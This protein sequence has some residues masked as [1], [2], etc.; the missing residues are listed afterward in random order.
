[1]EKWREGRRQHSATTFSAGA[2]VPAAACPRFTATHLV[3]PM[4]KSIRSGFP[5]PDWLLPS[6]ESIP[7]PLKSIRPP[8][9]PAQAPRTP[10]PPPLVA[11]A[12]ERSAPAVAG[13]EDTGGGGGSRDGDGGGDGEACCRSAPRR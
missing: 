9:V 1:M 7:L 5:P 8:S 12:A 6:S 2:S 13:R 3:S 11:A 10:A 4:P